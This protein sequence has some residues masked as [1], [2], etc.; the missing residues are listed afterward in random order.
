M[1]L[2]SPEHPSY[3]WLVFA[4]IA[5][6]TFLSVVDMGIVNLALP[7]IERDFNTN[8]STLQWV[9]VGYA[10]AISV[11]LLPLGR[12][13]DLLGRKRL[14]IAGLVIFCVAVTLGG[15]S[16]SIEM[17]IFSRIFQGVGGALVQANGMATILSTFPAE[18]RGK[19]I[20]LNLSVVG[21]GAVA[22][23]A[24]GGI[25]V[26]SFGWRS[27]FFVNIPFAIIAI[28]MAALFLERGIVRPRVNWRAFKFDWVG[29][30]LSAGILL[31]FLLGL[32]EGQ[33]V[34]WTA[35]P[36]LLAWVLLTICLVSF[37]WWE[38]R[39]KN[40]MLDLTLFKRRVLT[41]GI[42]S[43]FIQFM[44]GQSVIFLMT[45]Y[46]QQVLLFEPRKA[47]LITIVGPL[48]LAIV[49]PIS[50]RLSDRFGFQKFNIAGQAISCG[51]L[52]ML[53]LFLTTS[54]ALVVL[55]PLIVMQY[56]GLGLFNSPNNSSIL[57][58]VERS[59]YGVVS[60]LTQLVRNSANVTSIAICT[61]VIAATLA[62][63]GFGSSLEVV[64]NTPEARGAFV[65]GLN[66]VFLGAAA[67]CAVGVFLSFLKGS[68]AKVA[69][70]VSIQAAG[71]PAPVAK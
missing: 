15:I 64:K 35:P 11:L 54:T 45:F 12:M 6:G 70:P 36:I 1:K 31:T 61:T 32:S 48:T 34:G 57:G 7:T 44:A 56:F 41:F 49:G 23:P 18:E 51:A 29:A 25:L 52:L 71:T 10:L 50:G 9:T 63:H 28:V 27:V 55:M 21:A 4:T 65:L 24:L 2:A 43:G 60:A 5:L 13:G 8:L 22:G 69:E 68:G 59:R 20:G 67:L 38:L 30:L 39:N 42:L 40:P 19:A 47:G 66:R 26:S 62:A 16:Q 46:L 3:K 53:G 33:R 14:I 58:S 37:I 17:L